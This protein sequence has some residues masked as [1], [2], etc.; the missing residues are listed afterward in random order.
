[1]ESEAGRGSTFHFSILAGR[2]RERS[3]VLNCAESKAALAT[4]ALLVDDNA[5]N[6]RILALCPER[7]DRPWIAIT[8]NAM[9]G[10]PRGLPRGGDE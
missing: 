6:R 8:A 10:G 4:L 5:T 1:M 7:R 2:R 3:R 9:Q